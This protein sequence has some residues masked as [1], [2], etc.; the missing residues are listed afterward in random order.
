MWREW[1]QNGNFDQ[2]ETST[3]TYILR[4]GRF[5]YKDGNPEKGTQNSLELSRK[6][7][8]AGTENLGHAERSLSTR[9]RCQIKVTRS[10]A[11]LPNQLI[12]SSAVENRDRLD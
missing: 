12:I 4:D 1:D 3:P 2:G 5:I 8:I 7:T 10:L 11:L 6:K 9:G